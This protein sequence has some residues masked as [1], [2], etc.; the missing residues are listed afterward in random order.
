MQRVR[1]TGFKAYTNRP[2]RKGGAD[3]ERY[4]YK[5]YT[6]KIYNSGCSAGHSISER[7]ALN[8]LADH[9]DRRLKATQSW[10]NV[11]PDTQDPGPPEDRVSEL[12]KQ[13]A[14]AEK[15]MKRAYE[16]VRGR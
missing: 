2:K 12:A 6:C 16:G 3:G 14:K 13:R 8:E 10:Q 15:D 11:Q 5:H 4:A 7:R 9:V 1:E